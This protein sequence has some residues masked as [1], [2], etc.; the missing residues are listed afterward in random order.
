MAI[1]SHYNLD[2]EQMNIK[3]TF[4]HGALEDTIY[5]EQPKGSC[6]LK[7]YLYRLKQNPRKLHHSESDNYIYILNRN[8]EVIHYLLLFV[9][10]ILMG[11]SNM[12]EIDKLN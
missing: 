4:L 10:D 1:V 5:M 3:T 11:S 12:E 2:L 9:N 8:M 7:K 6:I